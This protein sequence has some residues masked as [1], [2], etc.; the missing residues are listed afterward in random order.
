MS[1]I[2]EALRRQR[3]EAQQP[4]GSSAPAPQ[5]APGPGTLPPST[6]AVPPP[7]PPPNQV[8]PRV[9]PTRPVKAPAPAL[10]KPVIEESGRRSRVWPTVL[11]V[12]VVLLLLAFGG[13]YLVFAGLRNWASRTTPTQELARTDPTPAAQ[14]AVPEH[15]TPP[16]PAATNAA[17]AGPSAA[18]TPT[19]NV[20]T[21]AIATQRVVTIST[22]GALVT[23]PVATPTDPTSPPPTQPTASHPKPIEPT[24]PAV[25][26]VERKPVKWP[27]VML[28][29][30]IRS[31]R[32]SSAQ[33]NGKIVSVGES[34]DGITVIAVE[35]Q[36]AL[37]EYDGERR[38][39]K[40][41]AG[42]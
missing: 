26:V 11:I 35:Y 7:A 39:F 40:V 33:L 4:N 37:L 23:A 13:I 8:P 19:S 12:L 15:V 29:G 20:V 42:N 10:A 27:R 1:L 17:P 32:F 41:R 31:G 38:F 34:T 30:T 25:P 22:P 16:I 28:S 21:T 24:N 14:P 36:G 2:E 3:E 6:T 18:A 9:A 5:P